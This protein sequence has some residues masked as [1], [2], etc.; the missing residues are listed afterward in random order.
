MF[1]CSVLNA[2]LGLR[3]P[4]D[5]EVNKCP[6]RPKVLVWP[7]GVAFGMIGRIGVFHFAI[8]HRM[9]RMLHHLRFLRFDPVGI[10]EKNY[11]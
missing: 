5:L 11:L 2:V 7:S 6:I 10:F 4:V 3:V 8:W 9:R 1:S